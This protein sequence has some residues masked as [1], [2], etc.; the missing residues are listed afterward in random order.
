MRYLFHYCTFLLFLPLQIISERSTP[1]N[2]L[3]SLG[4]LWEESAFIT[5]VITAVTFG[6]A[7]K[8]GSFAQT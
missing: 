8:A 1:C 5:Q 6:T 4:F 2:E 3:T 7:L